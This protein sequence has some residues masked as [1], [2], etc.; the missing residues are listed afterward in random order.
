MTRELFD[1]FQ[2]QPD[3]LLEPQEVFE[4][5]S[6]EDKE[7]PVHCVIGQAYSYPRRLLDEPERLELMLIAP[8]TLQ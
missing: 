7:W 1:P 6:L 2:Q 3:T 4:V 5:L 8:S